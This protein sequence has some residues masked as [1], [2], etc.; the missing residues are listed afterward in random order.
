MSEHTIAVIN[1]PKPLALFD[2]WRQLMVI[3]DDESKT[4]YLELKSNRSSNIIMRLR[5]EDFL[6][7]GIEEGD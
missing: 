4:I 7:L 2:R 3:R 6:K 5:E 1:L